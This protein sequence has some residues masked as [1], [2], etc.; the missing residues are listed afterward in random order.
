MN[1]AP[2]FAAPVQIQIHLVSAVA[3]FL[4]GSIILL[5]RKGTR[6]HKTLGWAYVVLMTVVAV[7]AVFIRR[8]E[9]AGWS[10]NGYT[11]IHLFIVLTAVSLPL[12]LFNIRRGNVKGHA[13]AMIGLFVGGLVIAGAL[14]LL[15]GRIM[16]AVVF[17]G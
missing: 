12:A 10:V 13:G 4:L 6:F 5:N 2:I 15:P 1:L 8:P 16:H 7:S 14:T 9:G 3:A 17:G 11:P